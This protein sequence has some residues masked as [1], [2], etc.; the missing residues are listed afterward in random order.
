M[1][2]HSAVS[3]FLRPPWTAG[4]Q[5]PCPSLSPWVCSNSYPLSWWWHPTISS[6]V[7][8]FSSCP[9]SFPASEFFPVSQFFI[10]GGLYWNLNFSISPSYEYAGLISFNIDWFDILAV[11]GTLRSL[12]QHHS[13]KAPVLWCSALFMVQLSLPYMTTGKPIALTRWTFVGKVIS[14]LFN[15]S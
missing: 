2:T 9:K 5:I 12:F 7:A 3:S 1:F 4:Q 11:Q 6:F 13:L 14:L 15:T 10:S 8:S